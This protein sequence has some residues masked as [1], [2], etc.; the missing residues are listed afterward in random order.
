MPD[1]EALI[2]KT[3]PDFVA[4]AEFLAGKLTNF[5]SLCAPSLLPYTFGVRCRTRLRYEN[6]AALGRFQ[7]ALRL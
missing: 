5:D 1:P 2:F 7:P 4:N 6:L 3:R